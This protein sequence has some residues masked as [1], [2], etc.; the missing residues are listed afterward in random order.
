M[1]QLKRCA[2]IA[3][4]ACFAAALSWAQFPMSKEAVMQEAVKRMDTI[5]KKLNLSPDQ[6]AKIKPLLSDQLEKTF[7]ARQKFAASDQSDAAKKEALDSIEQSRAATK[8]SVKDVLNPD[9]LKKWGEMTKDFKG[10]LNF[11]GLPKVPKI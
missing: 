4:A 9:Q 7:A 5:A 8:D 6:V 2:S 10:D 11:K 1:N 3:T